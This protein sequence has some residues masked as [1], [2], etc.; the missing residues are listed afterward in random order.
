MGIVYIVYED[1]NF[2][3]HTHSGSSDLYLVDGKFNRKAFFDNFPG[4][5]LR[6]V[7]SPEDSMVRENKSVY[8][9]LYKR[10]KWDPVILASP[11]NQLVENNG[12][13]P[14]VIRLIRDFTSTLRNRRR[15]KK[16]CAALSC[17]VTVISLRT[18]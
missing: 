5:H 7:F 6:D 1:E 2:E 8:S 9:V 4:C 10:R 3:Q 14:A 15:S 18:C 12:A 17:A 16:Y 11:F 13:D